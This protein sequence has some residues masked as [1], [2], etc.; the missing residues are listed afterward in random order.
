M[1]G[2][3]PGA[4][5]FDVV[6]RG[7]SARF[8]S[9]SSLAAFSALSWLSYFLPLFP[10]F[11][12]REDQAMP[13]LDPERVSTRSALRYRPRAGTDQSRPGPLVARRTRPRPDANFTAAATAPD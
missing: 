9:N 2:R 3:S 10:L 5:Q 11:R 7:R 6:L 4:A 12:R 8:S 1:P 13:V